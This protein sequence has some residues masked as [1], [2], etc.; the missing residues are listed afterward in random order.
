MRSWGLRGGYLRWDVFLF[1]DGSICWDIRIAWAFGG[2]RDR[3]WTLLWGVNLCDVAVY[4][5]LGEG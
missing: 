4:V 5:G 3:F 1:F 2:G